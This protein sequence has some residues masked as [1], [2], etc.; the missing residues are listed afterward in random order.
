[1]IIAVDGPAGAGKSSVTNAIAQRMGIERL[2][3][4]ALYRSIA[5]A[6][7][8]QGVAPQDPGLK[9][10]V[11]NTDV[12]FVKGAILLNRKDVSALIRTDRV[13]NLA[14]A[15]A[16]SPAV[17]SGLLDLQRT[18]VSKGDFIVDGRDIGTVVFPDADVKLFLTASV[19]ARARRRHLEYAREPDAPTLDAIKMSIQ[20]RDRADTQ[21]AIAP[22]AKAD[23]AIVVD[24]SEM[25]LEAV[26]DHCIRLISEQ[27]TKRGH[28]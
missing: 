26:V 16:S 20:E 7:D 3:T 19:D 28:S 25:D 22:L 27:L 10:F 15:Y 12:N 17:R 8:E 11:Q 21:R 23:D 14:S 13:S 18:I 5:L 2:D 24:S 9:A 4:G 1:M 6:A